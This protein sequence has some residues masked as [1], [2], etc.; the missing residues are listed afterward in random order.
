MDLDLSQGYPKDLSILNE[1]QVNQ[2]IDWELSMFENKEPSIDYISDNILIGNYAAALDKNILTKY[3]VSH[4]ILAGKD[5]FDLYRDEISYKILPLYDSPYLKLKKYFK[6]T[7]EFIVN[8]QNTKK[9]DIN[10]IENNLLV[11]CGSGISRSVSFAI[12][13]FIGE[14]GMTYE[15]AIK[16]VKE[17]RKIANPNQ[18]FEK[19]LREYSYEIHKKF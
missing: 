16:H 7:N 1:N 6:E 10:C 17:K 14:K 4:I 18:G 11:H 8:F 9:K 13:Y 15:E 12:A 19:E 5:M 2:I 3:N